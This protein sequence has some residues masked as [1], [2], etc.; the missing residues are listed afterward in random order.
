MAAAAVLF[1]V[2]VRY[3]HTGASL[4]GRGRLRRALDHPAGPLFETPA[5]RTKQGFVQI[6]PA[7]ERRRIGELT[8]RYDSSSRWPELSG[9]FFTIRPIEHDETPMRTKLLAEPIQ[10]RNPHLG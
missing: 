2:R 5:I 10:G 1:A 3:E 7:D 6:S 8:I 4:W 9:E